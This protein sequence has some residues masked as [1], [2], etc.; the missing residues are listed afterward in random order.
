VASQD[1]VITY[2][3]GGASG[4]L[5]V[6]TGNFV[7]GTP[8]TASLTLNG[9]DGYFGG[10]LEADGQIRADDGVVVGAGDLTISNGTFLPGFTDAL[11]SDGDTITPTA[12]MRSI[13]CSGDITVTLGA[14]CTDG[15]PLVIYID[16]AH[17][18]V[19]MATN[20][21][22]AGGGNITVDQYDTVGYICED[23]TWIMLYESNNS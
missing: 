3:I 1:D 13:S 20:S 10:T 11:V 15:Q 12:Y 6:S 22:T 18:V 16:D 17:S 14:S 19:I 7:V 21:K 23:N 8:G 2:T 9:N 5:V 4:Y